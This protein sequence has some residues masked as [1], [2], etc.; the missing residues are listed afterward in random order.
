M[1]LL[2]TGSTLQVVVNFITRILL[3]KLLIMLFA[4]RYSN[5]SGTQ[6]AFF[7]CNYCGIARTQTTLAPVQALGW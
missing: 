7:L 1:V 3:P 5:T 6:N 4:T 2:L